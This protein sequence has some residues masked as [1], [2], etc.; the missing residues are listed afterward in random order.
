MTDENLQGKNNGGEQMSLKTITKRYECYIFDVDDTLLDYHNAERNIM[1]KIFECENKDINDEI[2]DNLWNRSCYW[3]DQ[4]ELDNTDTERIQKQYHELFEQYLYKF[5]KEI[6]IKYS[7]APSVENLCQLF[8]HYLSEEN[9]LF[10]ETENVLKE[11]SQTAD[12][13]IAT[14][15]FDTIQKRRTEKIAS[16]FSNI[17][18]SENIGSIK[19]NQMFWK[20]V[21]KSIS[22]L[23]ENCLMVGDSLINDVQGA[24][25]YGI[26]TCWINRKQKIN[27]SSIKPTYE[28]YNL[29]S[30]LI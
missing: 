22:H 9:T 6:K 15:G 3:W 2:L 27:K 18:I 14:N 25:T 21:F 11:L 4:Y 30:L 29:N 23:P 20:E 19:P 24:Q 13:I 5:M 28:I 12:L 17:F 16:Y 10:L 1:I 8:K 26:D 7:L